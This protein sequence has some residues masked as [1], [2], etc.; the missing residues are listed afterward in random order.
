[1]S[2]GRRCLVEARFKEYRSVIAQRSNRHGVFGA[3]LRK[4]QWH[5][6]GSSGPSRLVTMTT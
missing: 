1:M 5:L 4:S 6:L 3:S 2:E